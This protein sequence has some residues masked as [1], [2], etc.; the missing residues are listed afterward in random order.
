MPGHPNQIIVG[1]KPLLLAVSAGED[2][3][4]SFSLP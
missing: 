4:D 2:S 3:F 1:Q